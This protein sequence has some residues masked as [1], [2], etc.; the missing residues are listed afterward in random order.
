MFLLLEL[1]LFRLHCESLFIMPPLL[2]LS[3]AVFCKKKKKNQLDRL[4]VL[5]KFSKHANKVASP[6]HKSTCGSA[7]FTKKK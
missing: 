1:F 5:Q 7:R 6:Q 2:G 4:S 3:T